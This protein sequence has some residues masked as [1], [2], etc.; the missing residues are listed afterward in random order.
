MMERQSVPG[1]TVFVATG[2]IGQLVTFRGTRARADRHGH[3]TCMAHG[4]VSAVG[5]VPAAGCS[6]H[7]QFSVDRDSSVGIATSYG[8]DGKGIE[9]R[10]GR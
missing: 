8:L 1:T 4:T 2:Q 3:V 10:C 9:S 5:T 7:S 6:I